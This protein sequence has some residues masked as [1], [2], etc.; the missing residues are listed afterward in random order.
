MKTAAAGSQLPANAWRCRPRVMKWC[1][2]R[3]RGGGI[4]S[5]DPDPRR[6]GAG[7]RRIAPWRCRG[8]ATEAGVLGCRRPCGDRVAMKKTS[9]SWESLGE[10]CECGVDRWRELRIEKTT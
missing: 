1:S 9:G 2:G 8:R 6:A 4:R 5:R 3:P 7:C 10:R